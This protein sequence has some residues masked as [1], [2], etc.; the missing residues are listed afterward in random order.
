MSERQRHITRYINDIPNM[1]KAKYRLH[2]IR[3]EKDQPAIHMLTESLLEMDK[4]Y[5]KACIKSALDSITSKPNAKVKI[6]CFVDLNENDKNILQQ[7]KAR[8]SE[9]MAGNN[10]MSQFLF[11]NALEEFQKAAKKPNPNDMFYTQRCDCFFMLD[12]LPNAYSMAL[13]SK[14]RERIFLMSTAVGKFDVAN[15]YVKYMTYSVRNGK[16]EIISLYELVQLLVVIYLTSHPLEDCL[17]LFTDL[18]SH[19]TK[20]EYP[21]LMNILINIKEQKF[22]DAISQLGELRELLHESIFTTS[23]ADVLTQK[24]CDNIVAITVKPF[25]RISLGKVVDMTGLGIEEIV[26]SI[27]RGIRTGAIYGK[28]DLIENILS[29]DGVGSQREQRNVVDKT[30]IVLEELELS[31]WKGKRK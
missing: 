28:L 20:Q 26:A 23:V 24:I 14:D 16:H 9:S 7:P 8:E 25:A 5:P 17:K 27:K 19:Q 18:T 6:G 22:A 3:T 13:N 15:S 30:Q 1:M 2:F 10:L 12:D 29:C 21:V 31:Q 11:E 4:Q